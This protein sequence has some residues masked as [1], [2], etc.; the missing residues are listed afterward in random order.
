MSQDDFSPGTVELEDAQLRFDQPPLYTVVILNDDFT[1]MEFVVYVLQKFFDYDH[2]KS[3][4]IMLQIHNE[5]KGYCG[6]FSLEI[7]ETKSQQINQ[8]S[9][10]NEHP[11]KTDIEEL[12]KD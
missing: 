2:A 9:K 1:P 5:G 6:A 7:A 3:T 12:G 4:E 8:F 10:E 11:L